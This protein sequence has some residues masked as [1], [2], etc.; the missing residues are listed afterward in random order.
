MDIRLK[1][2]ADIRI[3]SHFDIIPL[4]ELQYDS[5]FDKAHDLVHIDNI[6][7]CE[8]CLV[9][10]SKFSDLFNSIL[11]H[12]VKFQFGFGSLV[13]IVDRLS[14]RHEHGKARII[15]SFRLDEQSVITVFVKQHYAV[16]GILVLVHK[17]SGSSYSFMLLI[18]VCFQP[19]KVG[20]RKEYPFLDLTAF[21]VVIGSLMYQLTVHVKFVHLFSS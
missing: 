16:I 9:F 11:D 15:K 18:W 7:R 14:I 10:V 5:I 12:V 8:V 20:V 17:V 2:Y 6:S 19:F 1:V 3:L 13:P 4:S 21:G